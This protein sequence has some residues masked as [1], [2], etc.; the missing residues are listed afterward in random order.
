MAAPPPPL[1]NGS[2]GRRIKDSDRRFIR[3]LTP[4]MSY[5]Q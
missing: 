1:I 5:C 2:S 3:V 4:A